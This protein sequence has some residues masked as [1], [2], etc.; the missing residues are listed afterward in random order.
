MTTTKFFLLLVLF[1][2][3]GCDEKLGKFSSSGRIAGDEIAEAPLPPAVV[4]PKM[5]FSISIQ[6]YLTTDVLTFTVDSL[7]IVSLSGVVKLP[8]FINGTPREASYSSGS[9]TNQIQFTYQLQPGDITNTG[10]TLGS[11][12]IVDSGAILECG[13]SECD[14][15]IGS[16]DLTG[17][18][19]N[20]YVNQ[21]PVIGAIADK[22]TLKS[23]LSVT[24]SISDVDSTV[25]C[26]DVVA[27]SSDQTIAPDNAYTMTD[28]GGG[29]CRLAWIATD[30]GTTA[31]TL[32]LDDPEG[33]ST[34]RQFNWTVSSFIFDNGD[35]F[36]EPIIVIGI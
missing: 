9:G 13:S 30:S 22:T 16:L 18:V 4:L 29:S 23:N 32:T 28:L 24:F 8:F 17:I 12:L 5:D 14:T 10:I 36:G 20:A 6:T 33:N 25:S 15:E 31:I 7:E 34:I 19:I 11:N 21:A 3:V 27:H 26:A 1:I 2:L 35:G